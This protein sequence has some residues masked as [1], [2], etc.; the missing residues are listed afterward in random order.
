M[1]V[2]LA[3]SDD[4]AGS[5]C[6]AHRFIS[7]NNGVRDNFDDRECRKLFRL[8]ESIVDSK[9]SSE[10]F[11]HLCLLIHVVDKNFVHPSAIA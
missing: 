10:I 1:L 9:I 7:V 4:C 8:S 6:R 3:L 5:D 2:I 11:S